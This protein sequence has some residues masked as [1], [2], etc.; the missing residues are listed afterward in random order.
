M[1]EGYEEQGI[2]TYLIIWGE[3]RARQVIERVPESARV[4]VQIQTAPNHE[5]TVRLFEKLTFEPIRYSWF[6]KI[7][8]EEEPPAPELPEVIEIQTFETFNDLETILKATDEAFEDHWGH[9]DH[10]ED[11]GRLERFRHSIEEDETFDPSIW[12]LAMDDGEIAGAA[13]CSPHLGGDNTVGIVDVLGVRRP[14]RKQGLGLALLHLAFREFYKRGYESVGLGVDS[15][16]LSG[17]TRL[18]EKAGMHIETEFAVYEK[19]L[20]PGEELAKQS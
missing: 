1:Y 20:R 19:E 14:W 12:Y 2:G 3:A 16:N 11:T 4:S 18:Y 6:M 5:P 9:I 15:Q 7:D 8:L 13:L 10:S 17:A